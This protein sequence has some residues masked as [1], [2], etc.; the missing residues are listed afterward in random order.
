MAHT[1][2]L[3]NNWIA[4]HDG[5]LWDCSEV[6]LRKLDCAGMA[7]GSDIVVPY[8]AIFSLVVEH[9][10]AVKIANLENAS[11]NKVLGI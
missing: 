1:T 7:D 4:I 11:A 5:D 3:P 9:I 2:S 8:S 6:T 10:R